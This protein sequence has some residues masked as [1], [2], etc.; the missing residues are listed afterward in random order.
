M[1]DP[2]T[3]QDKDTLRTTTIRV[4]DRL[5]TIRSCR[6][7]VNYGGPR[8]IGQSV[9]SEVYNADKKQSSPVA[10]SGIGA[11][12]RKAVTRRVGTHAVRLVHLYS[13]DGCS[14]I[15]YSQERRSGGI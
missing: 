9:L 10:S 12:I 6:L 15:S 1:S 4:S 3:F 13:A 2:R 5:L 11:I 7:I 8:T 14:T